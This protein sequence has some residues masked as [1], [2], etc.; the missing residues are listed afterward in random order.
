MIPAPRLLLRRSGILL[1]LVRPYPLTSVICRRPFSSAPSDGVRQS[2]RGPVTWIGLTLT[3]VA[4]FSAVG[5]Y[6][7]EQEKKAEKKM[8]EVTT[9]GKP[10]VGGPWT[11]VDRSGRLVNE[12]SYAGKYT[13]LYFGFAHCPD[14]C[15]SELVKV[16]QVMDRLEAECGREAADRVVPLFVSV[17]P[18]RDSIQKLKEYGRDFHPRIE[19]LTGTP[20]QVR[21]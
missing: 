5:Y 15:P 14:I 20:E 16:A 1:P 21:M 7:I 19:F 8:R 17:D 9:T 10:A 2:R 6:K 18:A 3:A 12:T 11:L 13:L 4:S